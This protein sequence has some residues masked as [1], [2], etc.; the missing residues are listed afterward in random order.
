M[1]LVCQGRRSAGRGFV[2]LAPEQSHTMPFHEIVEDPARRQRL[3]ERAQ[4]LRG[5]IYLRDGAIRSW[6]L[7][8]DGRH[9][10]PAD[11]FSWHLLT[12]DEHERVMACIRYCA[13]RPGVSYSDLAISQSAVAQSTEFGRTV[14]EAIQGELAYARRRGFYYVELGGWAISEEMRCS[15]EALRMLLTVFALA[16]SMGGALG[17]SNA[18]TRHHSS[19]ILRRVGGRPLMVRGAEVPAY[20]DSNYNCEMELLSFDSTSPDAHYGKWIGE[21]RAALPELPVI[22]NDVAATDASG[23]FGPPLCAPD[24]RE[25]QASRLAS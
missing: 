18:T 6:E 11:D 4:R 17:V 10:Q 7:S 20:L 5:E 24:F 15:S 9:I 22:S 14:R 2:L 3:L 12:V 8:A 25:P 1:R 16:Q 13:H 19:S 23:V 21:C